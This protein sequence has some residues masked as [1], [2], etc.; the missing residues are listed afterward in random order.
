MDCDLVVH[1]QIVSIL[2]DSVPITEKCE[3]FGQ[4]TTYIKQEKR[5]DKNNVF[6]SLFEL[7]A[8]MKAVLPV[9]DHSTFFGKPDITANA[10][11]F[12]DNMVVS[13][14]VRLHICDIMNRIVIIT[15]GSRDLSTRNGFVRK[16]LIPVHRALVNWK[17][18]HI[19]EAIENA[20]TCFSSL[21]YLDDECRY[22]LLASFPHMYLLGALV[23][24]FL[25]QG[26]ISIAQQMSSHIKNICGD[27]KPDLDNICHQLDILT[28]AHNVPTSS[29]P[30]L[31]YLDP[32]NDEFTNFNNNI[33]NASIEFP[34]TA[35]PETSI[36][37]DIQPIS[38]SSTSYLSLPPL[39]PLSTPPLSFNSLPSVENNCFSPNNNWNED[40]ILDIGDIAKMLDLT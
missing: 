26:Q 29:S 23:K 4:L 24:L 28:L 17:S 7:V 6:L 35:I 19:I 40:T 27:L 25:E 14:E 34:Q 39:S 20:L 31:E 8:E 9:M 32:N 11:A 10:F 37:F 1:S 5:N 16:I 33:N 3:R 21:Q 15:E 13:E 30:S 18:G 38:F 36:S 2:T 12:L 22:C